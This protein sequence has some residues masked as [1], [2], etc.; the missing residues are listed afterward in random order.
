MYPDS[1]IGY[2]NRV[3]RHTVRHCERISLGCG[4]ALATDIAVEAAESRWLEKSA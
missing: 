4:K 2:A 3:L 1:K